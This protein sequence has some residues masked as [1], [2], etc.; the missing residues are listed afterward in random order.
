MA[1]KRTIF[2]KLHSATLSYRAALCL[3]ACFFSWIGSRIR[4]WI[5][6]MI[7]F[8][9]SDMAIVLFF[10]KGS[11]VCN[12]FYFSTPNF[13]NSLVNNVFISRVSG[14]WR[15]PLKT[16]KAMNILLVVEREKN[17]STEGGNWFQRQETWNTIWVVRRSL[18]FPAQICCIFES[19]NWDSS[20]LQVPML[21]PDTISLYLI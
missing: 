16:Q 8:H 19:E 21:I 15:F 9:N 13:Q 7:V 2:F 1:N 4:A 20:T 5:A 11:L 17:S 18:R 6:G 14:K 12:H 10:T 3:F